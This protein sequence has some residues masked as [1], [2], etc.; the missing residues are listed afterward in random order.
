M[1]WRNGAPHSPRAMIKPHFWH[2]GRGAELRS[3]G[4]GLFLKMRAMKRQNRRY[5]MGHVVLK[6]LPC[7]LPFD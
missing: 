2:D 1:L 5:V 7:P 4:A 3:L 6:W